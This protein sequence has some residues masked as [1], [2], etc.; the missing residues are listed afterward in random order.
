MTPTDPLEQFLYYLTTIH[1][2]Q[3]DRCSE[4]GTHWKCRTIRTMI[5]NF[6]RMIP[7]LKMDSP[8]VIEGRFIETE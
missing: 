5:T 3:A 2:Q 8:H 1:R 4:C 6:P 7:Y